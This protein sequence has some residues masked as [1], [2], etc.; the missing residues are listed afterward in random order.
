M[1]KQ[2]K[3][4]RA[5]PKTLEEAKKQLAE[6]K[7]I[8]ADSH[9][10][11]TSMCTTMQKSVRVL[12]YSFTQ[13]TR[14]RK[15]DV[16]QDLGRGFNPYA[17]NTKTSEEYLFDEDTMKMMKNELNA[18][19]PKQQYNDNNYTPKNANYPGKSQR[20]GNHQGY[21]TKTKTT[22]SNNYGNSN[23]GNRN[24]P[25]STRRGKKF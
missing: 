6:I 7:A 21:S 5:E 22:Y 15:Q 13:T 8:T 3:I 17:Q 20:G 10:D 4:C 1:V 16:C 23:N 12:A 11:M 14:K 25:K 24:N 9:K 19:K 2:H 18:I